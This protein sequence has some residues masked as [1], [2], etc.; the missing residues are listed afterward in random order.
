MCPS[1]G[2]QARE[3]FEEAARFVKSGRYE[4]ARQVKLLPSDRK[5]IEAR[6]RVASANRDERK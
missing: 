6:I 5:L 1:S 2:Q 4:E 3:A